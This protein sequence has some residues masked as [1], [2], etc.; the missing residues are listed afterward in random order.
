MV[1][2]AKVSSFRLGVAVA[3]LTGAIALPGAPARADAPEKATPARPTAS[4]ATPAKTP[5]TDETISPRWIGP[6]WE[7]K[8]LTVW[9]FT[10][11]HFEGR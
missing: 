10:P 5:A 6:K 9:V 2:M 1:L 3:L 4:K 7:I 8:G 11:G